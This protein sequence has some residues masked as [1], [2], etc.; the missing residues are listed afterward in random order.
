MIV[1]SNLGGKAVSRIT[2]NTFCDNEYA[3]KV[4]SL[5]IGGDIRLENKCLAGLTSLETFTCFHA[6]NPALLGADEAEKEKISSSIRHIT[7]I[8]DSAVPDGEYDGLAFLEDIRF[9]SGLESIGNKAFYN[10]VKLAAVHGAE[11]VR[12]VGNEAFYG[13]AE[14]SSLDAF[15]SL[16][17]IGE[18]AFSGSG[19]SG[20]LTIGSSIKQIGYAAFE[21]CEGI[22]EICF[23]SPECKVIGHYDDNG[24]GSIS[25]K[26]KNLKTIRIGANVDTVPPYLFADT[27]A[28]EISVYCDNPSVSFGDYAF[29]DSDF[30]GKITL[31]AGTKSIGEGCFAACFSLKGVEL[32]EGL[33]SI[34]K[35]A[36]SCCIDLQAIGL[37]ESLQEI[38]EGAF[39]SCCSVRSVFIPGVNVLGRKAFKNCDRLTEI[40]LD[41]GITSLPEEIF[42][43]CADLKT[44]DFNLDSVGDRAFF[45]CT[46][47][48]NVSLGSDVKLG[49]DVFGFCFRLYPDK[50]FRIRGEL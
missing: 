31:P 34:G 18:K 41:S 26:L 28:E 44:V 20:T 24:H 38:G 9:E 15:S 42:L 29:S 10:Y 22:T 8:G 21:N 13:C 33:L 7:V 11:N 17:T 30:S 4:R 2:G 32:P 48:E 40:T 25:R 5:R 3:A 49:D 36:F 46:S 43:G 47:L 14:M 19:I 50:Q 35:Q 16:E 39:E 27:G 23:D 45:L 37:P 1:P 6:K 12:S